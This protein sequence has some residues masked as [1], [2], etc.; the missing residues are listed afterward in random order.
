MKTPPLDGVTLAEELRTLPR[1]SRSALAEM[2]GALYGAPPP[3]RTSRSLLLRAVAYKLQER[4]YG[5]LTPA[6]RRALARREETA[7]VKLQQ[8][9]ARPGTVLLREWQGMTHRVEVIDS[10]VLYQ[11]RSYR[12]LSE[13]A[14]VITGSRWSGPR[15]FGLRADGK[16]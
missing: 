16:A 8:K 12:S 9:E 13:V 2:W 5:G 11:G 4:D 10:G 1:L 3:P 7:P 15:F 6:V 14:R